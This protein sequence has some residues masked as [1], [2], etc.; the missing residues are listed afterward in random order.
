MTSAT[1]ERET[2]EFPV[3][4]VRGGTSRAIFI[5]PANLPA[6]RERIEPILLNVLGSPDIR[7]INGLGGATPQTSKVAIVSRSEVDWADVDYL[8]AQVQIAQPLLDWGGNC[9]NISAAVGPYAVNAGL[10][11]VPDGLAEVRIRNV[12]TGKLLVSRFPVENGRAVVQGDFSIAGVPSRGARVDVD[13]VEPAG[14]LQL[15]GGVL[16]TGVARQVITVGD[17]REFEVSVVD[18]GNPTAYIRAADVGLTGAESPDE[19]AQNRDV[20][21]AAE[22]VR[23]HVAVLLGLAETPEEATL[24]S[25]GL[26]KMALVG[27]PAAY[28]TLEGDDVAEGDVDL[29]IRSMSMG[30]P[31]RAV[32][33]TVAVATT[34]AAVIPGTIVHELVRRERPV[35]AEVR[36]GHGFGLTV[37]SVDVRDADAEVPTIGAVTV[38]RTA[39]HI[40]DGVVHVPAPLLA[41]VRG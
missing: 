19:I 37:T 6:D 23:S 12:N 8:F 32:Q 41:G 24:R 16:P 11:D 27:A 22:Q 5:D 40:L 21:E 15:P 1:R 4:I 14:T 7:Q 25:P 33:I 9:G 31:H 18:A 2:V 36:L 20:V 28:R 29:L 3:S 10:V 26:P 39:R 17:G 13:F 34:A 35:P 38:A 30:S